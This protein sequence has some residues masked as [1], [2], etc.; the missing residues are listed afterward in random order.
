MGKLWENHGKPWNKYEQ[1]IKN[2]GKSTINGRFNG[3][4]IELNRSKWLIFQHVMFD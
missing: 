1:M 2:M 3:K 4:I